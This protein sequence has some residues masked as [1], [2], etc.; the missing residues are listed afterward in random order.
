M[1]DRHDV[2]PRNYINDKN[3]GGKAACIASVT[4][5]FMGCSAK[6]CRLRLSFANS[7]RNEKGVGDEG[8]VH[9]EI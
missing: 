1:T 9:V 7:V 8:W 5:S 6:D 4:V 2:V 3:G